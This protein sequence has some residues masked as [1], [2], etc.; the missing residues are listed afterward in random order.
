MHIEDIYWEV[1]GLTRK[2]REAG[3]IIASESIEQGFSKAVQKEAVEALKAIFERA[4]SYATYLDI[5]MKIVE[6]EEGREVDRIQRAA[7]ERV[8]KG[9]EELTNNNK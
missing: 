5:Q 8:N 7:I 1:E 2:L 6:E 9:I 4:E 3:K